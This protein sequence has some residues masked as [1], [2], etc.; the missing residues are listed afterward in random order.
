MK[1]QIR[2]S[3]SAAK[4]SPFTHHIAPPLHWVSY[5]RISTSRTHATHRHRRDRREGSFQRTHVGHLSGGACRSDHRPW[6]RRTVTAAAAQPWP[7]NTTGDAAAAAGDPT[8]DAA[9]GNSAPAAPAPPNQGS[10]SKKRAGQ[11]A[12]HVLLRARVGVR[13]PGCWSGSR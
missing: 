2:K 13:W 10:R 8:G 9:V 12:L 5:F 7:R 6:A 3:I 4:L 1:R 11:A